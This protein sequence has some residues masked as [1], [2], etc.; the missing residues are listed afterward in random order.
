MQKHPPAFSRL[1]RL[2][3]CIRKIEA[4]APYM[5]EKTA[6]FCSG[7]YRNISKKPLFFSVL[8]SMEGRNMTRQA[9]GGCSRQDQVAPRLRLLNIR[10]PTVISAQ[11][12]CAM[13]SP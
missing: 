3:S 7:K 9:G 4:F 10:C 8:L 1:F 12:Y 5:Y 11:L 2:Y 13:Y 6:A